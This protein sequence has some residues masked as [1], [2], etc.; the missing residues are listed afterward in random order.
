M[1]LFTYIFVS[2]LAL[3]GIS[4]INGM[5]LPALQIA[6][7]DRDRISKNMIAA[8]ISNYLN[9]LDSNK[10]DVTQAIKD[11]QQKFA[12]HPATAD[13]VALNEKIINVLA[14]RFKFSREFNT[15]EGFL[16]RD[17]AIKGLIALRLANKG[18]HLWI[19]QSLNS[20]GLN[21]ITS[22]MGNWKHRQDTQIDT[23]LVL[24][25][26]HTLKNSFIANQFQTDTQDY[27]DCIFSHLALVQTSSDEIK[28]LA[29]IGADINQCK[30]I[31]HPS[32]HAQ[33]TY[34]PL[35]LVAGTGNVE[36]TQALIQTGADINKQNPLY[37]STALTVAAK[38]YR[39]W[40][41]TIPATIELLLANGAD[42]SIQNKVGDT[43]LDLAEHSPKLK[44]LFYKYA[45]KKDKANIVKKLQNRELG[46]K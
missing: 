36:L 4:M 8:S 19:A 21:L 28:L 32:P 42:M 29:K 12:Y 14:D 35:M 27:F 11:I 15:T 24:E 45:I 30:Y 7:E 39:F 5:Q 25:Y 6:S 23:P 22:I 1:K 43:A 10:T 26:V 37:R 18:A 41:R 2:L 17:S 3:T 31:I 38:N 46:K 9:T 34:T 44:E 40:P 16:G 20:K 13:D 33:H